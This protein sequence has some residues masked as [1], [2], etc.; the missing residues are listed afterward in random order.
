MKEYRQ[1]TLAQRY[2]ISALKK[3]D[4]SQIA[5]ADLVGVDACTVSRELRRNKS[6]T[7]YYAQAAHRQAQQRR[8]HSRGPPKWSRR[9]QRLVESR[10]RQQWSPSR[11]PNG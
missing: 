8:L 2:E 1:L 10:L 6:P 7:G 11:S 3:A 5:I 4:Y 9:A